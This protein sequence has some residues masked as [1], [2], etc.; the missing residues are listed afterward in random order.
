MILCNMEFL[1]VSVMK[2]GSM[3]LLL[4]L[5]WNYETKWNYC[6]AAVVVA[7]HAFFYKQHFNKQHPPE[8][9]KK[10]QANVS[11]IWNWP[12]AFEN[13]IFYQ[14]YQPKIKGHILK[15]KQR[16]KCVCIH[17]ILGL[18]IMKM[19]MKMKLIHVD[20]T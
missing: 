19:K 20:M 15:N 11:T 13:Y 1:Y 16:N 4:I 5:K 12:F 8:I 6:F 7:L 3:F 18:T 17:E 14:R 10:N 2:A 9:G